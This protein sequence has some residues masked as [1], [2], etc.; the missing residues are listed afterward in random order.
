MKF[1]LTVSRCETLFSCLFTRNESLVLLQQFYNVLINPLKACE[2]NYINNAL[3]TWCF[4][5][6]MQNKLYCKLPFAIDNKLSY[7]RLFLKI[8]YKYSFYL[9]Y[10]G[11]VTFSYVFESVL[12]KRL[13]N[14][15][16]IFL[17]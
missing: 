6:V 2:F 9:V 16:I 7:S 17:G 5:R 12:F 8:F 13:Q 15:F 14:I 4:Q 1:L 11:L 3:Y 10:F